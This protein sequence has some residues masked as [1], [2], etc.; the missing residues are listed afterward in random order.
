[1]RDSVLRAH[2]WNCATARQALAQ[3]AT[4]PAW[5]FLYQY[6]LPTDPFCLRVLQM[7]DINAVF[8]IEGRKLLTDETT[9]NIL[10]IKRI[11]DPNEFDV[12]L[13]NA[14][15]WRMAARMAIPL[16][17]QRAVADAMFALYEHVIAGAKLVDGQES[18]RDKLIVTTLS[19]VR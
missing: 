9:A 2:P 18:P 4:A 15:Q 17:G 14:L 7:S 8:K 11:E 12:S 16:T 5:G 1:M 6:T 10:F 19:D 3:E 13:Y